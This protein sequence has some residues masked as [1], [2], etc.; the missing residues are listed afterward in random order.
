MHLSH[1][2][3]YLE[4][5][6]IIFKWLK[7]L[8]VQIKTET[9]KRAGMA[10]SF[11]KFEYLSNKWTESTKIMKKSTQDAAKTNKVTC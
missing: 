1:R 9:Y 6:Q 2:T 11:L 4:N 7:I 10:Q 8:S 3:V 5:I